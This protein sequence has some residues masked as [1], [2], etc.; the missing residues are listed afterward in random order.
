MFAEYTLHTS[1][2]NPRPSS[3]ERVRNRVNQKYCY[4]VKNFG[5]IACV[6]CGRCIDLCPVNIDILDIL[7]Q[8]VKEAI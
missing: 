3:R 7:S 1:G 2:H 5:K 4:Y 6:G 8:V